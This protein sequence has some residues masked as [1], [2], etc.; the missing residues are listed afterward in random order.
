MKPKHYEGTCA[1]CD[2]EAQVLENDTS[3]V[4]WCE[5]GH[6]MV[7]DAA[8]ETLEYRTGTLIYEF[9]AHYRSNEK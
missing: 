1:L 2:G 7:R 6:V 5:Y 9:G 3:K 8:G 4:S